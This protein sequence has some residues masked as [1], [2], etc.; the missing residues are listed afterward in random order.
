MRS[1]DG[2]PGRIEESNSIL[3]ECA[4]DRIEDREFS[5]SLDGEQQHGTNDHEPEQLDRGLARNR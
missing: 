1:G 5:K 3:I 4:V 2:V